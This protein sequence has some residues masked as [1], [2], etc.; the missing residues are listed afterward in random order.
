MNVEVC[1]VCY[2]I[3]RYVIWHLPN[4]WESFSLVLGH[5]EVKETICPFCEKGIYE[6]TINTP[7]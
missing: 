1:V 6:K 4:M 5:F 2:K 3:K 7:L